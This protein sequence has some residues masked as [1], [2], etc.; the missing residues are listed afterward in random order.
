[1]G[2]TEETIA[3][4]IVETEDKDIP[5]EALRSAKLGCFD[6]I[7]TMLAGAASPPGKIMAKFIREAGGTPEATV[8]GTGLR[9]SPVLAALANGTMAHVLDYD[10]FGPMGH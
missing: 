10:D 9:T 8:I 2:A 7:G 5:P 6:C 3:R 1:M 4:F